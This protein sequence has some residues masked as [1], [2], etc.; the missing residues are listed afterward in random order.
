MKITL[1]FTFFVLLIFF[2]GGIVFA[3]EQCELF[4]DNMIITNDEIQQINN[5][6]FTNFLNV[7]TDD[8]VVDVNSSQEK[9]KFIFTNADLN[10]FGFIKIKSVNL[11]VA[12]SSLIVCGNTVGIYL[13]NYGVTVVGFGGVKNKNN[14]IYPFENTDIKVGDVITK[15]NEKSIQSSNDIDKLLNASSFLGEELNIEYVTNGE[16]KI[17]KM[18]PVFDTSSQTYKLGLWVKNNLNGVGTLTYIDNTTNKFGALGH[19]ITENGQKEP[20][21]V[22]GGKLFKCKVFGISKGSQGSAGEIKAT[23]ST[24]DEVHGEVTDNNDFGVFGEIDENSEFKHGQ[25]FDI[26]GRL[27]AKPGKAY[28]FCQ[29]DDENIK[30]YEIEIIKTNYQTKRAQKSLIIRITDKELLNKTGGIIQGMSGSPIIQNNKIIG[31]ITHVF[32]NDPTKGFGIYLD[33]MLL[34]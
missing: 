28:I 15:I 24:S 2:L 5:N 30:A 3:F 17:Q 11:N 16:T 1:K 23:F 13:E 25:T 8:L 22:C 9:N 18:N 29:L 6:N 4:E 31:A 12:T 7:D 21:K 20:M 33:W 26:G 14:I 19:G 32:V 34:E 10:L 27:T